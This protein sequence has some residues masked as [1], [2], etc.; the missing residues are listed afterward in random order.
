MNVGLLVTAGAFGLGLLFALATISLACYVADELRP[1]V[2]G[3]WLVG[4]GVWV[5]VIG[6]IVITSRLPALVVGL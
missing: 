1:R 2:Y 3:D 4:V 5:G 6:A